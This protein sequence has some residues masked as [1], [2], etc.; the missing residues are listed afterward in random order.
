MFRNFGYLLAAGAFA[1][2]LTAPTAAAATQT[3]TGTGVSATVCS[4]PGNVQIDDSPPA[5]QS[6][7]ASGA[8]GGPY[9]VPWAEGSG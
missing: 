1:A 6:F 4:S 3:C 5:V 2:L 8:Y 7:G 9:P